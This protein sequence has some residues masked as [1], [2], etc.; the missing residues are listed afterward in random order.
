MKQGTGAKEMQFVE[1]VGM[2][3]EQ[4]GL[5]RMAGRIFGWLLIAEPPYQ[6]PAQLA[7]AVLAS[8]GSI[9]SMTRLLI[10][11][12]FIERFSMPGVRHDY[13]RVQEDACR[14]MVGHG[15]ED[16]IKMMHRLAHRGLQI[17][18]S[19]KRIFTWLQEMNDLYSFLE[20]ELPAL[21]ERWEKEKKHR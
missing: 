20:R 4:T 18:G 21:I 17:L 11:T 13:F 15:V 8:K 1:E 7:R 2:A 14:H 3:F 9:S 16:E 10:Q 6:S 5:P 12:G 19:R